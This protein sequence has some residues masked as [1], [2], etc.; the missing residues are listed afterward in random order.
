VSDDPS[1]SIIIAAYQAADVIGEAIESA[2]AQTLPAKEVI[3]CDDGSTD[4]LAGAVAPYAERVALITRARNGGE[5]RAKNDAAHAASGDFVVI[6]DA[7]D[8]F[9]PQRLE[10]LRDLA[11]AAPDADVLTT[12]AW[13]E[14]DGAVVRRC[15]GEHW[16]FPHSGQREE[17][18]RRNFVFGLAAVRRSRLLGA[19]GFD[20]RLRWGTDWDCWMRLILDG[21]RVGLVDAP[22]ARYRI[23]AQSLSAD[24]LGMLRSGVA[25]LESALA[26]TDL[27][28]AERSTA[29]M[30]ADVRRREL[31]LLEAQAALAASD[32]G[33][34]RMLGEIVADGGFSRATRAKAAVAWV[35]PRLVGTHRARTGARTFTGAGG[36]R[37]PRRK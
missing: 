30:A 25:I 32:P 23:R 31:R 16:P 36:T 26:R 29:L 19:G 21:A 3:V 14:H 37:V 10:A 6:L 4:D 20:P 8:V 24:R 12:D 13:L 35:A 15:Y 1:F 28:A 22:L 27:S 33:V 7:D 34:R 5:A 17:I 2:L 11:R 18:L 9:L